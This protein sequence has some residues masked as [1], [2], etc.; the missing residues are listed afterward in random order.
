MFAIPKGYRWKPQEYL[1]HTFY[2]RGRT[3]F[4]NHMQD[5]VQIKDPFQN[6]DTLFKKHPH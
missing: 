4:I 1:S 3:V 2:K 5:D 6:T